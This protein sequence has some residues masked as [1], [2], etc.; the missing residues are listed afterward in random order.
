MEYD[1]DREKW[2]DKRPKQ[3]V[4][5]ITMEPKVQPVF[6]EPNESNEDMN[7]LSDLIIPPV[8]LNSTNNDDT[9]LINN[10]QQII[11]QEQEWSDNEETTYDTSF[12]KQDDEENTLT[13]LKIDETPI[14]LSPTQTG[15]KDEEKK[16]LSPLPLPLAASPAPGQ[17]ETSAEKKKASEEIQQ[18]TLFLRMSLFKK[19]EA[20]SKTWCTQKSAKYFIVA[21][22]VFMVVSVT[23]MVGAVVGTRDFSDKNNVTL[24]VT[25]LASTTVQTTSTTT[26]LTTTSE[27]FATKIILGQ[28]LTS[29]VHS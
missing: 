25:T 27:D 13:E 28:K 16:P 11:T 23:V 3:K 14:A 19:L 12:E 2:V 24:N 9:M 7:D 15:V 21:V 6:E 18:P 22:L 4:H 8:D 17:H 20:L 10:D 5:W 29:F 26:I 1:R